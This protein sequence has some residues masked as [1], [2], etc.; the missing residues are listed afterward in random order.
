MGQTSCGIFPTSQVMRCI[1]WM[2]LLPAARLNAREARPERHNSDVVA[3]R[4]N[5]NRATGIPNPAMRMPRSRSGRCDSFTGGHSSMRMGS[6]ST[7]PAT[8][9]G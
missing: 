2:P 1:T 3:R 4:A 9:L 5:P 7:T 6:T 8:S